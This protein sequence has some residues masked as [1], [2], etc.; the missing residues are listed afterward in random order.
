MIK[1]GCKIFMPFFSL[2]IMKYG[3]H[4]PNSWLCIKKKLSIYLMVKYLRF[5]IL[6]LQSNFIYFTAVKVLSGGVATCTWSGGR[7]TRAPNS[8]VLIKVSKRLVT[9][10]V[11]QSVLRID[12]EGVNLWEK[13]TNLRPQMRRG[14]VT[15]LVEAR[16]PNTCLHHPVS[17]LN[18]C[19]GGGSR[20]FF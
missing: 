2:D 17:S 11:R 9:Q 8:A 4:L 16:A 6:D 1:S 10:V 14:K 3:T 15:Q 19:S 5:T 12:V 13:L 7:W 18:M 20:F